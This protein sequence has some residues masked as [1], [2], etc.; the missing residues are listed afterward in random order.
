MTHYET[1]G[2]SP[3]ATIEQIKAAHRAAA[4]RTHPDAGGVAEDFAAVQEA[5]EVLA[6]AD[7][8]RDYDAHMALVERNRL[9]DEQAERDRTQGSP[10]A[11]QSPHA[12]FAGQPWT[13]PPAASGGPAQSGP[14]QSGPAQG[15]PVQ[16]GPVQAGPAGGA[17]AVP[18]NGFTV[19][20]L[21]RRGFVEVVTD[22]GR[23][24]EMTRAE[25]K[26]LHV[27]DDGEFYVSDP[28]YT[29]GPA[30]RDSLFEWVLLGPGNMRL[31]RYRLAGAALGAVTAFGWWALHAVADALPAVAIAAVGDPVEVA[32]WVVL[33]AVVGAWAWPVPLA[34]GLVQ[35]VEPRAMRWAFLGAL[36]GLGVT[37][38][39]L[40]HGWWWWAAP[41]GAAAFGASTGWLSSRPERRS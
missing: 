11:R 34:V 5:F 40:G 19:R 36:V 33:A 23:R 31:T 14:A 8:R 22:D 12:D 37:A 6:D 29:E 7:R 26:R 27:G 15:G 20:Q 25:A 18:A 38:D 13:P 4:K 21:D 3:D 17:G 1:L 24:F 10:T 32:V 16:A 9:L 39:L 28:L 30:G 2:L 41:V 35:R